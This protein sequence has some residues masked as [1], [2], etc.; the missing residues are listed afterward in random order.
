MTTF[1]EPQWFTS[2]TGSSAAI[3]T[4]LCTTPFV[5]HG[6][7]DALITMTLHF[8]GQTS[9]THIRAP[10][11][12][13]VDFRIDHPTIQQTPTIETTLARIRTPGNSPTR[14]PTPMTSHPLENST[15]I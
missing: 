12:H 14:T 8:A 2:P 11:Q 13:F 3:A 6:P 4:Q 15:L 5:G 1:E 7:Q 10:P 9:T